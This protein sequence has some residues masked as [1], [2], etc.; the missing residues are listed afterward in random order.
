[1]KERL[2]SDIAEKRTDFKYCNECGHINWYENKV[3]VGCNKE[4]CFSD[5]TKEE[6]QELK[7]DSYKEDFYL[8]V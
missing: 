7:E 4:D 6:A 1:M 3:C 8:E 5:M 2:I